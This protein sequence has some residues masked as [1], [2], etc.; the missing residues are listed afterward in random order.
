MIVQY[1]AASLVSENKVLSHPASVDSIPSSANQ[2]DH[3]SMGTIGARKAGEILKNA[4]Q[5]VAM[6]MFTAC[7]AIDLR[8]NLNLGEKTL[9]A[10]NK[11]REYIPFIHKDEIMYPHIHTCN[12]LLVSDELLEYV[13]MGE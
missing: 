7:Q 10:Y 12:D 6:E 5:V 11:I 4:R 9:K 1:S 13:F 8:G 2:E 3:V